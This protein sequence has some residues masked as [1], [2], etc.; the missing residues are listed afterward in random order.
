MKY[1]HGNIKTPNDFQECRNT[2][3][4]LQQE[5]AKTNEALKRE[6]EEHRRARVALTRE[7]EELEHER[8]VH[9]KSR[10]ARERERQEY[11]TKIDNLTIALGRQSDKYI[12]IHKALEH[13]QEQ[14]KGTLDTL[15]SKRVELRGTREA[16]EREQQKHVKVRDDLER[17]RQDHR[18][19]HDALKLE[20]QDRKKACDDL[21]REWQDHRKTYDALKRERQDHMAT[22]EDLGTVRS[23]LD[24]QKREYDKMRRVFIRVKPLLVGKELVGM[25]RNGGQRVR[26]DD[27]LRGVGI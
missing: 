27:L 2:V 22:R 23:N 13:E 7:R 3:D 5:L 4:D 9:G 15:A 1:S 24:E 17:E 8:Q 20:Q 12:E 25:G 10:D 26:V 11:K 14:H 16:L 21:E 19:D 6:R 18:K